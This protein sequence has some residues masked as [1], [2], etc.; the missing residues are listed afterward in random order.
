MK[1][2]VGL[3][4]SLKETF[5]SIIN[6]SGVLVC[7]ASIPS[8]VISLT[9][10]LVKTK[11]E[12]ESLGIE[13]GRLSIHLCKGLRSSGFPAI[14]VDA[15]HMAAA[16]SA[17]LNKNDRNDAR[18]IAQMMRAGLYREVLVKSDDACKVKILLGSRRHLVESR[19]SALNSVRGLLTIYGIK[20]GMPSS[21]SQF[22][23]AV[24]EAIVHLDDTVQLSFDAMLKAAEGIGNSLTSLEKR[25]SM[26]CKE[27]EDCR[28]LMTIP[29]VGIV[30]AMTYKAAIDNPKR[31]KKSQ[32]V[33]AYFGL[34]PKQYASGEVDRRGFISKV[35]PKEGRSMLYEAAH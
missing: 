21:H 28:R 1:H 33:G 30:T 10:Y 20:I 31:F 7:E 2:Y 17:R 23:T 15:R 12:F 18:G 11:L 9:D 4:V 6:D 26:L 3:D 29:G 34:T 5:V 32:T 8:D 13:S 24:R 25:L 19:K 27:D 22:T 16:L 14:C 35:G